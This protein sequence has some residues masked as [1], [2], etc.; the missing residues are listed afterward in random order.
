MHVGDSRWPEGPGS[1]GSNTTNS[2]AP[3]VRQAAHDA[4]QKLFEVAAPL[5]KATP[6]ELASA[7]GRVFVRTQR[8]RG[9]SF[10]QAAAKMPGE[11]ITAAADRKRQFETYRRDIAGTQ[12]A[13]V[14]VDVESGEIRVLKVVGVN[15]CG[16][17]MNTLTAESQIIGAMIQGV[18]WA[19]FEN[20]VLDRN[21]GTMLNPNL[22]SYKILG[23]KDMFE[24]VPIITEVANAGNNTSAAG[25][26]EPPIV[27]A[28]A[29]I[30]NAVFNATGARVRSLP[31][32]PDKVLAAL[33]D[34]GRDRL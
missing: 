12:F 13:E 16:F 1:G 24:A 20:R 33:A 18:S 23:A 2:V 11:V 26:G 29:A 32:T 30:A 17:P 8:A 31:I 15:D 22:E 7:E 10:K 34:A 27:P 9:M 4:R 25:L 5:L 6:S 19:L 28:L 3:V 14:E 21:V